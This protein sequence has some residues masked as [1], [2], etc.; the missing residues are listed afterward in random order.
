MVASLAASINSLLDGPPPKNAYP[1]ASPAKLLAATSFARSAHSELACC[2]PQ[3]SQTPSNPSISSSPLAC[4]SSSL[5]SPAVPAKALMDAQSEAKSATQAAAQLTEVAASASAE[6]SAI[7]EKLR[8]AEEAM[9]VEKAA[10]V[11]KVAAAEQKGKAEV[12]K[13]RAEGG[14][15]RRRHHDVSVGLARVQDELRGEIIKRSEAQAQALKLAE[16][17]DAAL[18]ARDEALEALEPTKRA[19]EALERRQAVWN[20]QEGARQ[21]E[22]SA[23]RQAVVKARAEAAEAAEVAKNSR[24][25]VEALSARLV[26]L[27]YE[28]QRREREERMRGSLASSILGSAASEQQ[29]E[30]SLHFWRS[31]ELPWSREEREERGGDGGKGS[32]FDALAYLPWRVKGREKAQEDEALEAARVAAREATLMEDAREEAGLSRLPAGMPRLPHRLTYSYHPSSKP[33]TRMPPTSPTPAAG[34]PSGAAGVPRPASA[35]APNPSA[36]NGPGTPRLP[37]SPIPRPRPPTSASPLHAR[38]PLIRPAAEG[39]HGVSA[40]VA[41]AGAA[42]DLIDVDVAAAHGAYVAEADAGAQPHPVISAP[43]SPAAGV[44]VGSPG[45]SPKPYSRGVAGPSPCGGW[46]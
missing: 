35:V 43:A 39:A 23:A 14:E 29:R 40:P 28:Q 8:A 7:R 36:P 42:A 37:S 31:R 4:R 41:A 24:D 9:A 22:L 38:A 46:V 11:E 20:E 27:E 33:A 44:V 45:Q 10:A 1:G 3:L 18:R 26:H 21:R 19:L 32:G 2:G 12:E 13:V 15:L 17:R 5:A 34:L 25:E 6:A 30:D 16:E